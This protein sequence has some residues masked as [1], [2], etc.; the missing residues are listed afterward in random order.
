MQAGG[1]R[2][3]RQRI[4]LM[5][6]SSAWTA[7]SKG[8]AFGSIQGAASA[9]SSGFLPLLHCAHLSFAVDIHRLGAGG[10]GRGVESAS[11][12]HAED[13]GC[14][15]RNHGS[16][17][18]QAD[19]RRQGDTARREGRRPCRA[20]ERGGFCLELRCPCHCNRPAVGR[21]HGLGGDARGSRPAERLRLTAASIHFRSGG[22][23]DGAG[24]PA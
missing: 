22:L 7:Q 15:F 1:Q 16:G 4:V 11:L 12:R 18:P 20:A 9:G 6:E 21:G 14:L 19:R 23:A 13:C 3:S 8:K 2:Q 5:K 17:E 24:R 10:R